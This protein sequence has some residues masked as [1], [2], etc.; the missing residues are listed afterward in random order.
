MIL[1]AEG[2]GMIEEIDLRICQRAIAILE[3]PA[4][5]QADIAVNISGK[6]LGSDAFVQSLTQLLG[7][8]EA[9]RKRILFEITEST[10]ITDLPRAER[11]IATLRQAG[12]RICLDDF[13]AGASSF[14]YLQGLSID[15]VKIDG[16]YVGRI[17]TN[18]RDWAIL[19][20][21]VSM[22]RDLKI[23]TIAEMVER[24]DQVTDL[25]A[26]G[27]TYGQGFHLGRPAPTPTMP[28]G[29]AGSM[30]DAARAALRRARRK[31]SVERWE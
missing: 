4:A 31:G 15:Y 7:Q 1:F 21:M 18:P 2:V 20:A 29:A 16:A 13:G 22:C 26:L 27:V 3:S 9:L 11:I 14:P 30:S 5:G 23:G 19:R 28:A 6:S 12:H 25:Q 24:E 17:G 8:H 10:T